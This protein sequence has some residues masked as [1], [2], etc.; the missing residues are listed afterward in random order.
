MTVEI[1]LLCAVLGQEQ[2]AWEE[3]RARSGP[4]RLPWE[5]RKPARKFEFWRQPQIL[6]WMDLIYM[7][8]RTCTIS[9]LEYHALCLE[10]V[11]VI[12]S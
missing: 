7:T 6:L 9:L 5:K 4:A 3:A 11:G 12:M 2:E 8:I 10:T 1:A